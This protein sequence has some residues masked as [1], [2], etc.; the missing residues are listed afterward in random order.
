MG[1]KSKLDSLIITWPTGHVDKFYQLGANQS[2]I[3][4]EGQSTNEL[5]QV[6]ADITL[7]EGNFSTSIKEIKNDFSIDIFPNPTTNLLTISSEKPFS[8]LSIYDTNGRLILKKATKINRS[9]S[10]PINHLE[11]GIYWLNIIGKNGTASLKWVKY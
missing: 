7:L 3:I 8:E 5:I 6:D 10:V 1:N 2:L 11:N 9:L 4:K